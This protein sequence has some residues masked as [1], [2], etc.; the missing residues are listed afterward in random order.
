MKD[1][2]LIRMVIFLQ[3]KMDY[4]NLSTV[5]LQRRKIELLSQMFDLEELS[6]ENQ[7]TAIL[8]SFKASL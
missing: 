2:A 8:T 5:L 4:E 3:D 6:T 1:Q 7:H